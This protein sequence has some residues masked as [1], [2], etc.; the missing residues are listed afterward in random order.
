MSPS[1]L[2]I[3]ANGSEELEATTIHNLLTR[4]GVDVTLAKS[5]VGCENGSDSLLVSMARGMTLQADVHLAHIINQPFDLVVIPGGVKGAENL[6]DDV[7]AVEMIRNQMSSHTLLGAICAAPAITLST[8][9]LLDGRQATCYPGFEAALPMSRGESVVVD[10]KLVTSQG[11]GTA[12]EFTLTL[13]EH[14]L[15]KEIR[16]KVA[17]QILYS[18]SL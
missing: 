13:I 5:N 15:G 1:A 9:G 11:P 7:L 16:Q 14:L 2:L 6:R 12:I 18:G 3:I 8:H 4:A 17:D 10:G